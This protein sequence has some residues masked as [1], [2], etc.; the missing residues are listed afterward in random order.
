MKRWMKCHSRAFPVQLVV[1][2]STLTLMVPIA[3]PEPAIVRACFE[4]AV[5]MERTRLRKVGIPDFR[6]VMASQVNALVVPPTSASNRHYGSSTFPIPA[7]TSGPVLASLFPRLAYT[8]D[9]LRTPT[10]LTQSPNHRLQVLVCAPD[11][12]ILRFRTSWLGQSPGHGLIGRHSDADTS[13]TFF[14]GNR[15][16]YPAQPSCGETFHSQMSK[17][18]YFLTYPRAP[19]SGGAAAVAGGCY[20]TGGYLQ[21]G[22]CRLPGGKNAIGSL[23]P[24]FKLN[25]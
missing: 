7:S 11:R 13:L 9:D 15:L 14:G 4:R 5:T 24:K 20:N 12:G 16:C 17:I 23:V 18:R 6:E 25:R 8:F 2:G 10:G 21:A 1:L 22:S 3:S 19:F